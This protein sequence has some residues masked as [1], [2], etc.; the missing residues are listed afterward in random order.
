MRP[1]CALTLSVPVPAEYCEN[2]A[3]VWLDRYSI[4]AGLRPPTRLTSPHTR[5]SP[6]HKRGR[7][8]TR[9]AARVRPFSGPRG[10]RQRTRARDR[11]RRAPASGDASSRTP[12]HGARVRRVRARALVRVVLYLVSFTLHSRPVPETTNP[13]SYRFAKFGDLASW[14]ALCPTV[15][16]PFAPRREP[17]RAQISTK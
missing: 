12:S 7:A 8:P 4:S 9:P 11:P 15:R 1:P 3:R 13:V 6:G 5:P 2:E 14:A 17:L 10:T 16:M